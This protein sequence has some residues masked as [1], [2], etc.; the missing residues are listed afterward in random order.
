MVARP[1]TEDYGAMS[2]YV[3]YH[4]HVELVGVVPRT[5]FLPQPD[6]NSAIISLVPHIPGAVIPN[7]VSRS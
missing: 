5:V 7:S 6:V 1:D 2:I 4:A 3:Q